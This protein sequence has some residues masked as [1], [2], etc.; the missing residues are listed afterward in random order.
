MPVKYKK[1]WRILRTKQHCYTD[2]RR[3]I[4]THIKYKW[5]KI[6]LLTSEIAFKIHIY[7]PPSPCPTTTTNLEGKLSARVNRS[8][9]IQLIST[10]SHMHITDSAV[11]QRCVN[12]DTSSQFWLQ[13]NLEHWSDYQHIWHRWL[14]PRSTLYTPNWVTIHSM[15]SSGQ[16]GE[17]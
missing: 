6:T 5:P 12:S 9:K 1:S 15:A 3:H 14:W 17:L 7:S 2:G 10:S 11:A 13:Q 8:I 4:H 16:I